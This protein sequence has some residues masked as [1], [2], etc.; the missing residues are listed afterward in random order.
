[1]RRALLLVA[2]VMAV[3][4]ATG[5]CAQDVAGYKKATNFDFLMLVQ[6]WGHGF[7]ATQSHSCQVPSGTTWWTLHGLWP[8]NNDTSYPSNCNNGYP[9]DPNQVSSIRSMLNSYWTNYLT[10][11]SADS[12]WSHEWSKHGTCAAALLPYMNTEL[13]FFSL[14]LQSRAKF[15]LTGALSNAGITPSNSNTYTADQV[16]SA[17]RSAYGIT[18]ILGCDYSSR[19][20]SDLL[21]EI[22][23]CLN[24]STLAPYE[25]SAAIYSQG[26]EKRCDSNGF[27]ILQSSY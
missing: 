25:C 26:L 20:G 22:G 4:A 23:F 9:F 19:I 13:K 3:V 6:Q 21:T 11:D 10:G 1:M 2:I 8:S 7:C 16:K 17:I 18:P 24:K 15:D 27:L 5:T 12:F 14:A